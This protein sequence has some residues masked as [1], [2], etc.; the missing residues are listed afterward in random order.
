MQYENSTILNIPFNKPSE[1]QIEFQIIDI[2]TLLELRSIHDLEFPHRLNFNVI[3][4]VMEGEGIHKID[5]QSY[6]YSKGTVFFI[7]K[8]QVHAFKLNPDLKCYFLL[9]TDNFLNRLVNNNVY[10]IFDYMIYPH[11]MQLDDETLCDILNN[12]QLLNHQLKIPIDSYTESIL[13]SLLQSLLLQ[14]KR[15]RQEQALP[16]NKKDQKLYQDFVKMVYSS[17]KYT[18]H[19]DDYARRLNISMRT[20]TNLLNKYTRKSTKI[21]L[22][23]FLILEIK[24]YLLDDGLTIQEIADKLEF[25]EP[26]NLIKFF[27]RFE[28]MTPSEF[29][30]YSDYP[31]LNV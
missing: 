13:Q 2:Q 11:D 3:M 22:N 10:D 23:E 24:R 16:L 21:Y 28:K 31:L 30:K 4:I 12:I 8:Y 14:L 9:F 7:S 19:V 1:N 15:K 6:E 27:K 5:F 20:L 17:H 26:T 25:D 29:K 18:T